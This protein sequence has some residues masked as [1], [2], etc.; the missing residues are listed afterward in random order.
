LLC[1]ALLENHGQAQFYARA[2][3][4]IETVFWFALFCFTIPNSQPVE[5][6]DSMGFLFPAQLS[7]E[8][9]VAQVVLCL[10]IIPRDDGLTAFSAAKPK[11]SAVVSAP[12]DRRPR[13]YAIL[14][15]AIFPRINASLR[16]RAWPAATSV[17]PFQKGRTGHKVVPAEKSPCFVLQP[18]DHGLSNM[19]SPEG[20][21]RFGNARLAFTESGLS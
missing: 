2:I 9:W 12:E 21:A 20:R 1:Q 7:I 17:R 11:I 14:Y 19:R 13:I 16:R 15:L 8:Q 3:L 5:S 10:F 18:G 4:K 6:T